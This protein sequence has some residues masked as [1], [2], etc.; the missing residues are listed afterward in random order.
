M[1]SVDTLIEYTQTDNSG[2]GEEDV[3]INKVTNYET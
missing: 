3:L 2:N 1:V